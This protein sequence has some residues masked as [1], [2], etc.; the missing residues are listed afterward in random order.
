MPTHPKM[1]ISQWQKIVFFVFLME[2][3]GPFLGLAT[4]TTIKCQKTPFKKICILKP[5]IKWV[6]ER[7]GSKVE[8][9]LQSGK[10][11]A[12]TG[13][14][15][16]NH[17]ASIYKMPCGAK[18]LKLAPNTIQHPFPLQHAFRVYQGTKTKAHTH[19]IILTWWPDFYRMPCVRNNYHI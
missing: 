18:W 8:K 19:N 2:C 4:N 15:G 1:K 3:Q 6:W 9:P 12:G 11:D 7:M 17:Q 5:S 14:C 16:F 10:C 13:T